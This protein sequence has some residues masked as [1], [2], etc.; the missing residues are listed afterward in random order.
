L[1]NKVK[2]FA[3]LYFKNRLSTRVNLYAKHVV[4]SELCERCSSQVENRHHVFF[5]CQESVSIWN[6]IG[7]SEMM[8][9]T[10]EEA[11]SANTPAGLHAALWPFI[12][13]TILWHIWDARNRCIFRSENFCTQVVVSRVC[14]D[15]V[16]W[17][18]RLPSDFVDSLLGWCAYLRCC[19]SNSSAR[20]G[21]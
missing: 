1:P 14:Y 12:F 13:L 10:D 18:K 15:L 21:P 3:W 2:V 6:T 19:I 7:M 17:R 16:I 8:Q 5:G 20:S 11:W 9:L 4:D